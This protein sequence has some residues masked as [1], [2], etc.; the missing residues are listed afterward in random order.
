MGRCDVDCGTILANFTVFRRGIASRERLLDPR[1]QRFVTASSLRIALLLSC[2][3]SADVRGQPIKTVAGGASVEGRVAT[4]AELGNLTD[5]AIDAAGNLYIADPFNHRIRRVEAATG[6]ITNVAGN[7]TGAFSGDGGPATSA[8][9]NSPSGLA[10]DAARNLYIADSLNYRVRRVDAATGII[11]TV[12]GTG[13][14]GYTGDG[15]PATS[16]RISSPSAVALDAAG[17]LYIAV[18]LSMRIRMVDAATKTITTVAGNGDPAFSGDGGPAT[19]ASLTFPNGVAV[20]SSG[21][22]FIADT[23]NNR[24]RRVDAQTKIMTTF[25][26]NGVQGYFGDGALASSA[27]LLTAYHVA[28]DASG[29][30]FI[31]DTGNHA[32]RKVDAGST[33]ISSVAGKPFCPAPSACFGVAGFSGDGGAATDAELA[34]PR[35]LAIDAADNVFFADS[36]NNR[37][38]R[39]AAATKIITTVAGNGGIGDGGP[40]TAALLQTPSGTAVDASGNLYIAD[41]ANNRVRRV[42]A[43]TKNI[44]TIEAIGPGS[45]LAGPTAVAFDS[46]GNLFIADALQ[47]RIKIVDAVTKAITTVAGGGSTSGN[48]GDGGPAT[49]AGLSRP[50]GVAIDRSGNL[51][52]ADRSNYRVRRVDAVTKNIS[53]VAGDGSNGYAGDGALATATGLSV[54][55]IALDGAGNLYIAAWQNY[56]IFKVDATTNIITT[57]AGNGAFG[58][59]GDGGP[60]TAARLNNPSGIAVDALGNVYI[61]D[62]DNHRIRKVDATTKIISTISGDGTARFSG[63]GGSA[64]TAAL[65]FPISVSLDAL[66]NLYIADTANN[67]VR[68]VSAPPF[69]RRAVRK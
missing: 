9:L 54:S 49:S 19:A 64:A 39:I 50:S 10:F 6:I 57:V 23:F 47:G 56:R 1:I 14:T 36:S 63:D 33:V 21:D 11:T 3:I 8:A 16:A 43:A 30:L 27:S 51:Y 48:A 69:R 20:S 46:S 13:Q 7:G 40:A 17:N 29:N 41:T 42:D 15:G 26:G 5:V 65:A 2:V 31:A 24:V 59:A 4:Q 35:G 60:A 52:I 25:A 44:T 12:A 62:T 22:L 68:V 55:A 61:A 34:A 38:R 58:Y 37:V 66:G 32:I 18:T 28:F 45:S 53:T 67:R